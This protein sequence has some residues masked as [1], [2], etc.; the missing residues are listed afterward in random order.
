MRVTLT[1]EL[2]DGT[3]GSVRTRTRDAIVAEEILGHSLIG[4]ISVKGMAA[5]VHSSLTNEAKRNGGKGVLPFKQWYEDV[6]VDVDTAKPAADPEDQVVVPF[7]DGDN[8]ADPP[9]TRSAVLP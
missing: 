3:T 9:D 8:S 5:M 1:Y 2:E 7:R 4:N 6:L